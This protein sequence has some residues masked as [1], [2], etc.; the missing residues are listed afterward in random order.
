VEWGYLRLRLIAR[1]SLLIAFVRPAQRDSTDARSEL[2]DPKTAKNCVWASLDGVTR[3]AGARLTGWKNHLTL[4]SIHTFGTWSSVR[5][6]Q[7]VGGDTRLDHKMLWSDHPR[8]AGSISKPAK[9][10]RGMARCF[11]DNRKSDRLRRLRTSEHQFNV[12]AV[13]FERSANAS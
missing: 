3:P 13:I 10:W 8:A 1:R 9:R 12:T 7:N 5:Y 6:L 2:K 11:G 4:V